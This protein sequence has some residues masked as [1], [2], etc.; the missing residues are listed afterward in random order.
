MFIDYIFL[1]F[2]NRDTAIL[3]W[4][5]IAFFI[6]IGLTFFNKKIRRCVFEILKISLRLDILLIFGI[7]LFYVLLEIYILVFLNLWENTYISQTIFWFFTNAIYLIFKHTNKNIFSF[8]EEIGKM[9]SITLFI[10][11]LVNLYSFHLSI[12]ILFILIIFFS[13]IIGYNKKYQKKSKEVLF[14]IFLTML[15]WSMYNFFIDPLLLT[16][17]FYGLFLI[18]LLGIGYI[19]FLY[20]MLIYLRYEFI[21]SLINF[22]YN[23]FYSDSTKEQRIKLK[24]KIIRENFLK[25]NKLNNINGIDIVKMMKNDKN[26]S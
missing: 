8:V 11:L 4:I 26:I 9:T 1:P 19:P 5:F 21:F 22:N 25:L 12:E 24:I 17:S 23:K 18:T 16:E 2:D 7:V 13:C 10:G 14:I 3:I 20:I 15:G 6:L